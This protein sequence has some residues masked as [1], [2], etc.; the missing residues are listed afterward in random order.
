MEILVPVDALLQLCK[1][2]FKRNLLRKF[3]AAATLIL[4]A[5][6]SHILHNGPEN[7]FHHECETIRELLQLQEQDDL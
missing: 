5:R 3:S 2:F 6:G 1:H 4:A 7:C